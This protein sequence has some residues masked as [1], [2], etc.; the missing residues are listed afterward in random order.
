MDMRDAHNRRTRALALRG[1]LIHPD[2]H[3]DHAHR[4]NTPTGT[5][6]TEGTSHITRHLARLS[7][8]SGARGLCED[9][10]G[11]NTHDDGRRA[12]MMTGAHR[13]PEETHRLHGR[14]FIQSDAGINLVRCSRSD[15]RNLLLC[16][17]H[18]LPLLP[19]FNDIVSRLHGLQARPF[20]L[21]GTEDTH[22]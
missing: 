6:E 2:T 13:Q 12:E 21:Y 7:T 4:K 1:A 20:P 18:L 14:G 15:A 19:T 3:R 8:E 9:P 17:Q 16:H 22:K 5:H 10:G 11:G